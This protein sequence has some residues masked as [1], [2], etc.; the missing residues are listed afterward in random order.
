MNDLDKLDDLDHLAMAMPTFPPGPLIDEDDEDV[1]ILDQAPLHMRKVTNRDAPINVE[2]DSEGEIELPV[3]RKRRDSRT[4]TL[5]VSTPD[6]P[7]KRPSHPPT[8]SSGAPS[9]SGL[10]HTSTVSG[11]A[12]PSR[13]S[14][15]LSGPSNPAAPLTPE[16]LLAGVLEILPDICPEY[17]LTQLSAEVALGRRIDSP[18]ARVVQIALELET[19]YPKATPR[20]KG[21]DKA[22]D[23]PQADYRDRTYRRDERTGYGY[24]LRSQRALENHFMRIPIPHIR[25][26]FAACGYM[27]A[28]TY[29]SLIEQSQQDSKPYAEL[30][31]S[32][33]PKDPNERSSNRLR[34]SQEPGDS[35]TDVDVAVGEGETEFVLEECWIQLF[36]EDEREKASLAAAKKLAFDEAIAR[37]DGVECGCCFGEDIPQEM[38][39]CAD[40]H[41]FCRDCATR[42]CETKLGNQSPNITC[43]DTSGCCAAFTDY[44]LSRLLNVKSLGLYYRLVRAKEIELAGIEGLESCPGCDFAA[45]IDNPN[46]KLFRCESEGCKMVS[47]RK[48]KRAE[49]LP[50][51]CEEMEL[52]RKLDKRHTVEDAMSEALIRRCPNEKCRKPFVKDSGCN[53][54]ICT[55]CHTLSCYVCKKAVTGYDH[56]DQGLSGGIRPAGSKQC[57]LWETDDSEAIMNARDAAQRTVL[58]EAQREGL[59]IEEADVA[60]A[61]PERPAGHVHGRP[62]QAGFA[63]ARPVVGMGAMDQRHRPGHLAAVDHQEWIDDFRA[64]YGHNPRLA[65]LRERRQQAAIHANH[66]NV[67]PRNQPYRARDLA[68]DRFNVYPAYVAVHAPVGNANIPDRLGMVNP[69]GGRAIAPLPGRARFDIYPLRDPDP[70]GQRA[71]RGLYGHVH[72]RAAGAVPVV[73]APMGKPPPPPYEMANA[74]HA[75]LRH[76]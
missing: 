48:C 46:E 12:G 23:A 26:I 25:L 14:D 76:G 68:Q 44:E 21:K 32:R 60:V 67:P 22:N 20:D 19:G 38:F 52:D 17:A 16:D 56:F 57:L 18:V 7:S 29:F 27:Y 40:G 8:A 30:K 72:E 45:I 64:V 51:S 58:A 47:C 13:F 63:Y 2:D 50:K 10:P 5:D 65:D 54:I 6:P 9:P 39:Q 55:S 69:V 43:M 37:G 61:A 42:H 53:K 31:R 70:Q 75:A 62:H 1:I 11:V 74:G 73:P 34:F 15:P 3:K 41:L 28:P 24:C 36:L 49:H 33:P 59:A 4:G 66:G 35:D 71:A